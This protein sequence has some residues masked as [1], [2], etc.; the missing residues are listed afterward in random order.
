MILSWKTLHSVYNGILSKSLLIF[1]LATPIALMYNLTSFIPNR[2]AVV[3][4]G[5]LLSLLGYLY[6][7]ISTPELIKDFKNSHD[8]SLS[9]INIMDKVD[10]IS[11]FKILE[12]EQAN[13]KAK[14]DGYAVKLYEFKSIDATKKYLGEY[15]AI[16]SLA[17]IKF[18]YINWSMHRKRFFLSLNFYASITLIFSSTLLHVKTIL[19]G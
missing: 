17:L 7:E 13:L 18:D 3:L 10:W 2:F 4:I 11:E 12:D 14:T 9:L 8:Y 1:S 19:L 6:T 15:T 5:A 16:R